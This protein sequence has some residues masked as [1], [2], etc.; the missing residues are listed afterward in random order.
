M[1]M[2]A[3]GQRKTRRKKH[4]EEETSKKE[5]KETTLKHSENRWALRSIKLDI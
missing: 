5:E 1:Y 3:I 4:C 2:C